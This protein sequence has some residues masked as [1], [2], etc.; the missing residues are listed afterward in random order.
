VCHR[1]HLGVYLRACL[2][3]YSQAGGECA[4][5]YNCES[6]GERALEN[7][8]GGVLGSVLRVYLGES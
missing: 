5:E 8:L 6:P 1:V 3:A 7:V 2:G 4:I